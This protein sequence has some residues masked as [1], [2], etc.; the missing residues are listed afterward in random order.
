MSSTSWLGIVLQ[1]GNKDNKAK[2]EALKLCCVLQNVT[3]LHNAKVCSSLEVQRWL[4]SELRWIT[5]GAG[6]DDMTL[7]G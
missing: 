2:R 1:E 6:Q 4:V 7:Y 3:R 5:A